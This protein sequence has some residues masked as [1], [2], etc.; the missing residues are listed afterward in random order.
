MS[1][2]TKTEGKGLTR[3]AFLGSAAAAGSLALAGCMSSKDEWLASTEGEE[4]EEL[5][6]EHVGYTFHQFMCGG[7]CSLKCTARDGRLCLIE[8]NDAFEDKTLSTV[9]ARGIS[10]IQHVYSTERLQ[11]PLKRVGERGSGEFVAISWDEAF[12]IIEEK[13]KGI[14][15][16]YGK[17][18]V[19]TMTT[20][21]CKSQYNL[22]SKILGCQ[23]AGHMGN[24]TGAANSYDVSHG[25]T[26]FLD[27]YC[28][29]GHGFPT[30]EY[31]DVV[32]AKTLIGLGSN[33]FESAVCASI[34]FFEA[35]EKG[36][37]FIVVDPH[38]STTAGKASEWVRINPAT[39]GALLLAMTTEVLDNGWYDEEFM[40]AHT[41][42]PFL[43]EVETGNLAREHEFNPARSRGIPAGMLIFQSMINMGI[44]EPMDGAPEQGSENAYLVWD[45]AAQAPV[46]YLSA[47]AK[48]VLEGEFEVDGKKYA[49]VFTLLKKRQAGYTA[50]WAEGVTGIAA[51]KIKELADKYANN[52][53]SIL[54]IGWGGPD[55]YNNADVL[56]H[57]GAILVGLTGNIGKPGAGIGNYSGTMSSWRPVFGSWPL[58]EEC[59]TSPDTSNLID[60]SQTNN[61]EIK[62]YIALGDSLQQYFP[63]RHTLEKW[64]TEKVEFLLYVDIYHMSGADWADVVLPA[65]TKFECDEEIGGIVS[66]K[67]HLQIRQ[68]IIDPLFE[69]KT[70]FWI[71]RELGKRFGLEDVLPKTAEELVRC[72]LDT[73]A[74]PR[75][76]GITLEDIV[77]NQGIYRLN[78]APSPRIGFEDQVY[79][80]PSGRYEVYYEQK[81]DFD[82][83]LPQYATPNE[84]YLDNPDR[85]RFPIILYNS[86]PSDRLDGQ[87]FSASWINE[88]EMSVLDL[89]GVDMRSRG[90]QSGDVVEVFNDRGS[91]QCIVNEN[92]AIMPGCGRIPQGVWSKYLEDGELNYVT[93]PYTEPR[94]RCQ[95]DGP[96]LAYNDTIVEIKKAG[97]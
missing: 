42:F 54:S 44:L 8:P 14:Q 56:G 23:T 53:P 78:E 13:I 92:E 45:E 86:R 66:S 77:A 16:K 4:P 65:C 83:A 61:D 29:I 82:Q 35:M 50:E 11:T 59:A 46:S 18:A 40:L 20:G 21:E 72:M 76:A 81:L 32:N 7:G 80:T 89:N 25:C 3:R 9:C 63:D 91:F 15:E 1:D 90:L 85:E 39:D 60:L 71:E 17:Q 87:F 2:S 37:D 41:S 67:N 26:F 69:S 79:F 74:T 28:G 75:V 19:M 96:V 94:M 52:G 43:V 48:P 70:D 12:D 10:E 27:T 31:N 22:I 93:N 34:P 62:A 38:F 64:L 73:A 95:G 33:V 30:N 97:E 57:A 49:T 24:D 58:P 55:K 47:D 5:Q 36:T 68:K 88:H 51:A 84:A 6:P